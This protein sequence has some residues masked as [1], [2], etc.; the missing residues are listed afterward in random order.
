MATSWKTGLET[1]LAVFSAACWPV[2]DHGTGFVCKETIRQ[3]VA[4]HQRRDQ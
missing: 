3:G 1:R 2:S 4:P